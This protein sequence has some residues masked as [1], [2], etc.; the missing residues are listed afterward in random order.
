MAHDAE[1]AMTRIWFAAL[2]HE[3]LRRDMWC[4]FGVAVAAVRATVND[5][6]T[7][8]CSTSLAMATED[9]LAGF[10]ARE[11][12]CFCCSDLSGF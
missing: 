2:I 7:R 1:Y 6:F 8:E 9:L 12:F 11:R 10:V 4:W 5:C 3:W